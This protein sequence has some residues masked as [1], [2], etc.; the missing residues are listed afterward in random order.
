MMQNR[1]A[2][3]NC[4][5]SQGKGGTVN[6]MMQSF[7]V[8]NIT[9]PELTSDDP[10]FTEQTLKLAITQGID[11]AGGTLKYPMPHWQ[12]SESDLNDLVDFIKTLK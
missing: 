5:G 6:M 11:P 12:M 4:H 1:L 9:W 10:P 8:P 3:V 2:C 7:D